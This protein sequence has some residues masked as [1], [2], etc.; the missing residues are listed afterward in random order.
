MSAIPLTSADRQPAVWRALPRWPASRGRQQQC[1]E[2]VG[3]DNP[4]RM[5]TKARSP[6][7]GMQVAYRLNVQTHGE[8][9]VT[10]V[11]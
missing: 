6:F 1:R 9:N 2:Q 11:H 7:L 3:Q 10:R 4:K 8:Q 5:A